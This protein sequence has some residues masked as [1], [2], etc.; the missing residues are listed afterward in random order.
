MKIL[1]VDDIEANVYQLQ[2]L[3]G[4]NGYTVDTA[5]NGA[6]AL[7]KARQSPPGLIITDI[8]M[9][10]MDGF[11]LCREWMQDERLKRIPLIFY[12]ATYTDER[13]RKFAL[14]LGAAQFMVKPVDHEILLQEI[15]AVMM[16]PKPKPSQPAA[17]PRPPVG[18]TVYLQ[19]YSEVLIRKLEDKMSEL[20]QA[21]RQLGR[22]LAERKRVEESLRE[23]E[24]RYQTLAAVSPVGIFRTDAQ[25]QTTYVNPCWCQISGLSAEDALGDGWLRAVHPEDR[26]MLAQGWKAASQAHRTSTADYRFV[27]PDGTISW[28]IGQSVPETD[29]AGRVVGYVGTITD[30]TERRQA[31]DSLRR[32]QA[33][34]N[35]LASTIPDHI[36][37]KDRQSRFVR[38]NE[39]MSRRFGLSHPD[40]A[41]GKTDA[42]MFSKEHARQAYA[43]EQRIMESGEPMIGV[44]EKET[45]PD[46]HVTWVS[47]TKVALRDA[48]GQVTGLVGVS[49]DITAQKLLEEKFLHAQRL[50]SLGMLAA[51]ISHDLNNILSPIM[52]AAPML[53]D[54]LS[55]PRDLKVLDTLGQ[56]ASRGA[57]LVK[58][59][60]AFVHSTTGDFQA[61]QVRHIVRDLTSMMEETF[62]KSIALD[63]QLP[64]DLWLVQ[65]NPTQIHQVLLNLCVNARD[66]MPKGGT[67]GLKLANRRLNAAEAGRIAGGRVGDWLEITVSDTGTGIPPELL[68]KIWSPFFTTKG[69][70]QGTGLG[71]S[72]VRSI[73]ASHHGFVELDTAVGR[74]TT[75]RVFLPATTEELPRPGSA[76]PL[77]IPAAQGERIIVVDDDDGVRDTLAD[78]LGQQGYRVTKCADGLEA[79]EILK[80][81][82]RDFSLVITD[83]DMPRLG[84]LA[85][86]HAVRLIDP[87]MRV[88]VISGM[89]AQGIPLS[90]VP[91]IKELAQAFLSK[92]FKT[93]DLLATVYQV[94][95][96]A[97]KAEHR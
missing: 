70:G 6:V 58:Q 76:S 92:P 41:V 40:D 53:R 71:L 96:P 33:L 50:E 56:S 57:A 2:V 54:S 48:R 85:L 97:E 74:G 73:V 16:E 18:D 24:R 22:D 95:H 26:R 28:V 47:T 5:P 66:A 17:H 8:L 86:V 82:F 20:E 75:F 29:K 79:N 52:F 51:G 1:V 69:L 15:R 67:L 3:L 65:C 90:D 35:S 36:Y 87:E 46:G 93:D 32:E 78:I 81:R 60:L 61:T 34:F 94:L 14:E 83:I 89:S 25:G 55:T 19:E 59:I 63:F 42:D 9:P 30:V 88:L 84:G 45:W 13:D 37:F 43:D 27:R 44:E 80:A 49:R 10:V 31:E 91:A 62:P 21:N 7:E 72:T 39:A 38:I 11:S 64:A 4:G 77:Q 68:E 12:T 23:S